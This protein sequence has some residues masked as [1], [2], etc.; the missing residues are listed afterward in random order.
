MQIIVTEML[1]ILATAANVI[2]FAILRRPLNNVVSIVNVIPPAM[3][4]ML[5]LIMFIDSRIGAQGIQMWPFALFAASTSLHT[6]VAAFQRRHDLDS[7]GAID[8]SKF[9]ALHRGPAE[10]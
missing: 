9:G 5:E 4:L 7:S 6:F 8:P 3:F 10:L 1:L 2:A